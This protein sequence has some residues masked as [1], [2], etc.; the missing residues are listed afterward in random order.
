MILGLRTAAYPAPDLARARDWY[1]QVLGQ[2]PYFDQPFCVGFSVG[3]FE[4]GLI[5]G[6]T[7]GSAGVQVFRGVE[8]ATLMALAPGRTPWLYEEER[9]RFVKLGPHG[10]P[11]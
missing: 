8:N 5:P 10:D 7:P 6:A 3:G 1:A 9:R 11:Q 4:L 2:D